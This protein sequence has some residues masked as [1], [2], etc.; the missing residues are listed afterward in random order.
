M[1]NQGAHLVEV[2]VVQLQ[3]HNSKPDFEPNL[4]AHVLSAATACSP[5]YICHEQ[6][7]GR[8]GACLLCSHCSLVSDGACMVLVL[9]CRIALGMPHH[10]HTKARRGPV[11]I[12]DS[13]LTHCWSQQKAG[14][15]S[16]KQPCMAGVPNIASCSPGNRVA[17][18]T[19]MMPRVALGEDALQGALIA[20]PVSTCSCSYG[21]GTVVPE[22]PTVTS[23]GESVLQAVSGVCCAAQRCPDT[24]QHCCYWQSADRKTRT[25]C[26]V[27][28]HVEREIVSVSQDVVAEYLA[29]L[30]S[31]TCTD[32]QPPT[33]DSRL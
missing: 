11:S 7:H 14:K 12:A 13:E 27:G 31:C 9:A 4:T 29:V 17:C 1:N 2:K 24:Q 5:A 30:P 6:G 19:M 22:R 8:A 21:I 16:S 3:S 25:P 10:D 32:A 20:P 26:R 23:H 18:N 33:I 15:V 28:K